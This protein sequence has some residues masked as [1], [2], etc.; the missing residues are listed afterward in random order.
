MIN[1]DLTLFKS[2]ILRKK[3]KQ[4][5]KCG[6]RVETSGECVFFVPLALLG[7][8]LCTKNTCVLAMLLCQ[9]A[10]SV[11]LSVCLSVFHKDTVFQELHS[12]DSCRQCK[13]LFVRSRQGQ[14]LIKAGMEGPCRKSLQLC[15]A[16]SAL[17]PVPPP[18]VWLAW[19]F[20]LRL[21]SHSFANIQTHLASHLYHMFLQK[22]KD[23]S[24]PQSFTPSFSTLEGSP[25]P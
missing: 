14:C 7:D 24:R 3:Q 6:R 16:N 9:A 12:S 15:K 19:P 25:V 23:S 10:V 18:A 2:H 1:L 4:K 13:T 17:T 20:F 21:R 8:C 22:G 5:P 11:C